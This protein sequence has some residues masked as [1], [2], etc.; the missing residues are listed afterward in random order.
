VMRLGQRSPLYTT[1][2]GK[3]LLAYLPSDMQE[4]YLSR[5]AL[6]PVTAKSIRSIDE[7]RRQL[8]VIQR[9][10][11]AYSF[12][13]QVPGIVGTARPVFAAGGNVVGAI[14]IATAAVR[15]DSRLG[16]QIADAIGHAVQK[17]SRQ[18]RHLAP[19]P[20]G[21]SISPAVE[22]ERET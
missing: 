22:G 20:G 13:E 12:E 16:A 4:D 17:L 7:L 10:G 18:L 5:V 3:V 21:I 11:I 6:V 14:S 1:S 9:D 19:S 8:A 2:Y 15:Y